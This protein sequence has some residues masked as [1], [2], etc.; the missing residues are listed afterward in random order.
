[1]RH[2]LLLPAAMLAGALGIGCSDQSGVTNPDPGGISSYDGTL[3][4]ATEIQRFEDFLIIS[5][6]QADPPLVAL[7]GVGLEFPISALVL[8]PKS[9]PTSSSSLTR[10]SKG[11]LLRTCGSRT[12]S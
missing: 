9:C 11:A 8:R 5:Q 6:A 1:M 3:S 2:A 7:V 4:N 12:T 10:A